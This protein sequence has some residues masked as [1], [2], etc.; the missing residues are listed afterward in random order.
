FEQA[1]IEALPSVRV[2]PLRVAQSPLSMECELFQIVPVGSGPLAANIVI[3]KVVLMH[4]ADGLM[5]ERGLI[6]PAK[7]D[8]IARM[9]ESTYATTR[10]RFDLPR[11]TAPGVAPEIAPAPTKVK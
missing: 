2:A 3:G 7:L 1:G 4:V 11:P 6:D 5:N 8:T 9:G 10:D